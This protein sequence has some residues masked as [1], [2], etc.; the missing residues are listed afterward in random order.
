MDA[1]DEV[2]DVRGRMAAAVTDG[3]QTAVYYAYGAAVDGD[4]VEFGTMSGRTARALAVAMLAVEGQYGLS[5]RRLHLYDSFD[6]LPEATAEPDTTSPHVILG[7]WAAGTCRQLS[8]EGLTAVVG[9]VLQPERFDIVPGWFSETVRHMPASQRFALVHV[10]CDLYAS[11]MDALAPLFERRQIS[12]GAVLCFDDWMCN[13]ASP[14]HGE[15][16]AFREL[17][18][19]FDVKAELWHTYSWCAASFIIHDYKGIA[20]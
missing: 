9:D 11:T 7:H 18:E 2:L 15:R 19:R 6:G 12:A 4:I 20:H 3:L 13:R 16:R 5:P 17:Q 1:A 14:H 10:D 8:P